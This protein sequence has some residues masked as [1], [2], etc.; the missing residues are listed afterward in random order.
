MQPHSG[1]A[2]D[3]TLCPGLLAHFTHPRE[4]VA[5][6][7]EEEGSRLKMLSSEDSVWNRQTSVANQTLGQSKEKNLNFF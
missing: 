7:A 2:R 3:C 6:V 4:A 5:F 1:T